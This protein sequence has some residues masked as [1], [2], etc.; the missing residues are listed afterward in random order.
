MMRGILI[1][2]AALSLLTVAP[3]SAQRGDAFEGTWAFQTASYGNE[4]VGGIMSGAAVITREGPNRY[5]I[6]LISNE[7]LVNRETSQAAFLTARQNCTGQN[8]DGQFTISCQMAEP[9]EGYQPDNFVLQQGEAD[10]LV[11][12]LSSN[13]SSQV[14]FSR[15]R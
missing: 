2:A 5:A 7:R 11:G 15:L 4:Q 8:D 1:A 9:L 13:A 12:V 14:T 3:A 6:R 10:Q